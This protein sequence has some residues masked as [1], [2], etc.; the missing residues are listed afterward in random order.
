HYAVSALDEAAQARAQLD[1]REGR[2]DYHRQMWRK[3]DHA[4]SH[5]W[6][7]VEPDADSPLALEDYYGLP[8]QTGSDDASLKKLSDSKGLR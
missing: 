8:G 6:E 2:L 4:A 5:P 3:W 7:K 1:E